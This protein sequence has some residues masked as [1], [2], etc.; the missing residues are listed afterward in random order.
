MLQAGCRIGSTPCGRPT[1][2]LHG[3]V[4]CR[5]FHQDAQCSEGE[6]GVS[7]PPFGPPSASR[8]R[9]RGSLTPRLSVSSRVSTG[10][11]VHRGVFPPGELTVATCRPR[12]RH[13]RSSTVR[14]RIQRRP[15]TGMLPTNLRSDAGAPARGSWAE[16]AIESAGRD[17]PNLRPKPRPSRRGGLDCPGLR[18]RLGGYRGPPDSGAALHGVVRSE[19]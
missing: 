4:L 1:P 8:P 7:D 17:Q 16:S 11:A 10:G 5:R 9:P 6:R 18:A 13:P 3:G 14:V 2:V 19:F 15:P 12:R